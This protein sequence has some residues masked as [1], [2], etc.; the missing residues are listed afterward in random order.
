MK[1]TKGEI[2]QV[3]DDFL[4]EGGRWDW[5]DFISVRIKDDPEFDA[6]RIRCA[7]LPDFYPPVRPGSYCSDDGIRV[8]ESILK[9]LRSIP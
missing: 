2:A 3:I 4:W 9:D 7:E 1:T 5:D 8:L 6:I